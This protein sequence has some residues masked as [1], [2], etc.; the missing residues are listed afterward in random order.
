MVFFSLDLS[1]FHHNLHAKLQI[2]FQLVEI[3]AVPPRHQSVVTSIL[4][5]LHKF[6]FAIQLY[7]GPYPWI[8]LLII[9]HLV[10]TRNCCEGTC[11]RTRRISS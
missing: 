3:A 5:H 11:F 2:D 8:E 4:G 1:S 9:L 6:C 10:D 7:L